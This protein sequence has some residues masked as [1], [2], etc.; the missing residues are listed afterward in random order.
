MILANVLVGLLLALF[1]RKLFWLFV[2]IAGFMAGMSLA[3]EWFVDIDPSTLIL[4][5]VIVG[6]ICAV[7]AVALR[8]LGIAIAG[9]LAG[10][11]LLLAVAVHTQHQSLQLPLFLVGGIIGAV[12]MLVIFDWAL[13]V[14][15]AFLGA[16]LVAQSLPLQQNLQLVAFIVLVVVGLVVQ[17]RGFIRPA[18]GA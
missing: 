18:S 8:K 13:I 2:A 14:L 15:S 4:V 3:K 1:G 17:V 11:Q 5:G 10:G 16:A 12:L 6:V 7:L 9:F